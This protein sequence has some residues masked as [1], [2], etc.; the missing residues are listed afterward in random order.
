MPWRNLKKVTLCNINMLL[1]LINASLRRNVHEVL[2]L[3]GS[4][5]KGPFIFHAVA[6][7]VGAQD[8]ISSVVAVLG[9]VL[10]L[11]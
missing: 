9:L 8:N 3:P 10:L 7:V 2:F 4:Q 6:Y 5:R 1:K 11:A